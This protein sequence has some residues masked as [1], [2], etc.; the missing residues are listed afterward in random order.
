MKKR[1]K[2]T[3]SILVLVLLGYFGYTHFKKTS[4]LL[5]VIHKDAETVIKIGIHDITKTLVLDALSSP[6][7]YWEQTESLR[8]DKK[9]DSIKKVKG[10][11]L[12]PYAMAFYTLKNI[13]N[14][15]FTTLKIDDSEAFE[16]YIDKYSKKKSSVI[17]VNA[18]GYKNLILEK[19]KLILAW[20]S[21]KIAVALTTNTS[22]ENIKTVFEDVLL[23]NKLISDKNHPIIKKLSKASDHVTFLN[24]ESLIS[25]NFKDSE[26][27]V[28]GILQTQSK[29]RYKTNITYNSLPEA[30]L[31]FY[32]DANFDKEENKKMFIESLKDASFFTK[33]NLSVAEII[34]K[35]KG[36]FSATISGTTTQQDTIVSYEYDDNFEKIAVKTLQEKKAP[37]I[38]INVEVEENKSLMDYLKTQGAIKNNVLTSIPYYTF[39]AKENNNQASFNTTQENIKL[40]EKQSSSFFKLN[41]NFNRLQE[42]LSIPKANEVFALLNALR[43]E[44]NQ[45]K[46][47]NQIK[48]QGNLVGK[49][50]DINIASQIF[51]GFQKSESEEKLNN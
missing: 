28:D 14:T 29:D 33:N 47:T 41:V 36:Y 44:A 15:L 32:F 30:A 6:G 17:T 50:E 34:D 21:E 16:K 51:F 10:V 46:S 4:V 49:N 18:K 7:Y 31:Q 48:I 26:A 8:K 5:N 19:S 39:Y 3:L 42:D 1:L 27:L 20:N 35:S 2:I 43:I 13:N 22:L 23:Y 24:K 40:E 9:K 37:K 45:I 38:S 12:K 25:L 11:D